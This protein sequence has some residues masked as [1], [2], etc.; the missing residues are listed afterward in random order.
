M[1]KC[2][3]KQANDQYLTWIACCTSSGDKEIVVTFFGW[4]LTL[5]PAAGTAKKHIVSISLLKRKKSTDWKNMCCPSLC[6]WA[7]YIFYP[8]KFEHVESFWSE[9]LTVS[10]S[11]FQ[12]QHF[13]VKPHTKGLRRSTTAS[14]RAVNLTA[15]LASRPDSSFQAFQVEDPSKMSETKNSISS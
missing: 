2:W 3:V 14:R 9:N 11:N 1:I 6:I 7:F 12:A 5:L 13:Q 4:L 15:F 10:R 8:P